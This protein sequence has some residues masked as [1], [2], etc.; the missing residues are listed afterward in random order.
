MQNIRALIVFGKFL[1]IVF[2]SPS[3]CGTQV[4][5]H[6]QPKEGENFRIQK[7]RPCTFGQSVGR[8]IV[9]SISHFFG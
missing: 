8:P 2:A 3:Q 9:R 5:Q 1:L 4:N 6:C 7:R